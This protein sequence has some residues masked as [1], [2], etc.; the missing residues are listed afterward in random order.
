VGLGNYKELLNSGANALVAGSAVFAS[1]N[2]LITIAEL[3]N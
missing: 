2:P 1:E 3:K